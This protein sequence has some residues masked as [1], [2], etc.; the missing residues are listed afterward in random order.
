[1]K[2]LR[3]HVYV[4]TLYIVISDPFRRPEKVTAFISQK[5]KLKVQE[6]NGLA[7][8]NEDDRERASIKVQFVSLPWVTVTG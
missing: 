8:I 1:M 5:Q 3:S 2:L 6:I 7:Y 4:P